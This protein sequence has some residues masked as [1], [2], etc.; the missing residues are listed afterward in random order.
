MALTQSTLKSVGIVLLTSKIFKSGLVPSVVYNFT[1]KYHRIGN[2]GFKLF[3]LSFATLKGNLKSRCCLRYIAQQ[4]VSNRQQTKPRKQLLGSGASTCSLIVMRQRLL[5]PR[6]T[7]V[8]LHAACLP[9]VS[10]LG[11]TVVVSSLFIT[12]CPQRII[13]LQIQPWIKV[14]T[15][16]KHSLSLRKILH[17]HLC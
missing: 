12:T 13:S 15:S 6:N 17:K 3:F 11:M 14:W 7:A 10:G 8:S 4:V 16:K 2:V 5:P 9:V 1:V